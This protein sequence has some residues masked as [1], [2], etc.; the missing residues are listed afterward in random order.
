[1]LV[2][3]VLCIIIILYHYLKAKCVSPDVGTREASWSLR[4]ERCTPVSRVTS[5][6]FHSAP[7]V[8]DV[9]SL[10]RRLLRAVISSSKYGHGSAFVMSVHQ[11]VYQRPHG[12]VKNS[13]AP[14]G[15]VGA[16]SYFK[17]TVE[18]FCQA[19]EKPFQVSETVLFHTLL[20]VPFR[21]TSS[22]SFFS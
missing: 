18:K 13:W 14:C 20:N 10:M 9:G 17:S 21:N 11:R 3:S 6:H 12:D 16:C 22:S 19:A 1:M 2:V 4:R 8:D 5:S 15:W 7:S